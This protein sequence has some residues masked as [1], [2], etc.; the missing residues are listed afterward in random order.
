MTDDGPNQG[1]DPRFFTTRWSLIRS[2]TGRGDEARRCLEELCRAYWF[3]LYAFLRRR[4]TAPPD[5]EDL[6]QAF[7]VLLLERGDLAAVDPERGRFRSWLR[8]ALKHFVASERERAATLKRGGGRRLLSIDRDAAEERYL[9][10]PAT[11]RTPEGEFDH[12]WA[13]ATL[14]RAGERLH[15]EYRERGA[16]DLFEALRPHLV[17]ERGEGDRDVLA[18]S[19]GLRPGALKVA[20]HRLRQRFGE[21]LRGEIAETVE[22]AEEVDAELEDLMQALGR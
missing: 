12:A 3:P 18:A 13:L 6:V 11:D 1:G 15:A 19:L 21:A 9:V 5:A 10:E 20:I 7:F 4:G 8:T 2:A 17:A 14:E 16:G 22:S